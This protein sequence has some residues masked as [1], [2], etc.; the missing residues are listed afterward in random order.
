MTTINPELPLVGAASIDER[1]TLP[2]A[3]ASFAKIYGITMLVLGLIFTLGIWIPTWLLVGDFATGLG[4]GLM[5]ALWGAPGF[6]IMIAGAI[7][8]EQKA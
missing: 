7:W 6:G 2:K 1:H 3:P 5:S 8:A 4:V